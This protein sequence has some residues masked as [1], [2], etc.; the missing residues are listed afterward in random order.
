MA[1]RAAAARSD[2]IAGAASFHGGDLYNDA[3]TSPH[4]LLP[5]VRAQLYFGHAIEDRRDAP[6]SHRE[7]DR[8]LVVWGENHERE[9]YEAHH[10]WTVPDNPAYNERQAEHGYKKLTDLLDSILKRN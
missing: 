4:T 3:P 1:L 5:R 2:Q 7:A 8:A 9:T 6:G 10:G